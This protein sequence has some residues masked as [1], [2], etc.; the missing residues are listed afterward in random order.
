MNM[1]EGLVRK[2]NLSERSIDAVESVLEDLDI[3]SES[4][5]SYWAIRICCTASLED[6]I[7]DFK[8]G[9]IPQMTLLEKIYASDVFRLDRMPI[10]VFCDDE[11]TEGEISAVAWFLNHGIY[12]MRD[13]I[14]KLQTEEEDIY[15]GASEE[16]TE[17]GRKLLDVMLTMAILPKEEKEI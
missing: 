11:P 17:L 1:Q 16:V 3:A 13:F 9:K 6:A 5:V 7:N 14:D 2:L 4:A 12:R 15:D 10:E 8:C